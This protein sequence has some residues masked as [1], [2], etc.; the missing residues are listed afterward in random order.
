MRE[1]LLKFHDT[2]YSANQ[3]T[4]AV[5][6]KG[7]FLRLWQHTSGIWE[8]HANELVTLYLDIVITQNDF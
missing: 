6:G 1:Q 4:L 5:C 7:E 2:Y 3:M 8:V